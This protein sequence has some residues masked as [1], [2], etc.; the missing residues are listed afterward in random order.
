MR[1]IVFLLCFF[2]CNV[3]IAQTYLRT[4]S[5][6]VD[7][8]TVIK[9]QLTVIRLEP[10]SFHDNADKGLNRF[11]GENPYTYAEMI[12]DNKGQSFQILLQTRFT[13]ELTCLA[14]SKNMESRLFVKNGPVMGFRSCISSL[15]RTENVLL[16]R[17]SAVACIM[18][19]LEAAVRTR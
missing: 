2:G 10:G 4:G 5:F 7:P 14:V 6:R 19:Q 15:C 12:S 16:M 18:N 17:E 9:D 13:G 1:H 11:D 8:A 3:L